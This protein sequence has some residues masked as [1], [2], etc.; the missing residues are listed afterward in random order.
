MGEDDRPGAARALHVS[1]AE[2]M[3]RMAAAGG[4]AGSGGLP[5][6]P[7]FSHGGLTMGLYAPF[8]QDPQRPHGRDEVYIVV[9][10]SGTF[11]DGLSRRPFHPGD[12]LVVPAAT[13]HRFESF[14]DDLTLWVVFY[15]PES[16][17][18]E[19]PEPV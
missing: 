10:G 9:R 19:E 3:Q 8:R 12:V 5:F 6:T 1:V 11:F 13:S 7:A 17:R 2:M 15:G 14:T 18:P 16:G 4:E